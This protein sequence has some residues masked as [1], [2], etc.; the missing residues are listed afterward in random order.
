MGLDF[1]GFLRYCETTQLYH[2]RICVL[3]KERIALSESPAL[4]TYSLL[5]IRLI[6]LI[7]GMN[8]SAKCCLYIFA[9]NSRTL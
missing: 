1:D 8:D 5:T 3:T 7:G 6:E 4:Q 9:N 2:H